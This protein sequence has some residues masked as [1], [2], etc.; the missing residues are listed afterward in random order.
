MNSIY[1]IYSK[2][3]KNIDASVAV[4]VFFICKTPQIPIYCRFT[5]ESI[6]GRRSWFLVLNNYYILFV[7]LKPYQ[8]LFFILLVCMTWSAHL[9]C[10]ACSVHLFIFGSFP[11]PVLT[12]TA[13]EIHLR[14]VLAHHGTRRSSSVC[15]CIKQ[16]L[17]SMGMDPTTLMLLTLGFTSR[18]IQTSYKQSV[19]FQAHL[20][21]LDKALSSYNGC[22]H[23]SRLCWLNRLDKMSWRL[24]TQCSW[25]GRKR[26]LTPFL[27][28]G[29]K[30]RCITRPKIHSR[31]PGWNVSRPFDLAGN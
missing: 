6:L 15:I 9:H 13:V 7:G 26:S 29:I 19:L 10:Q 25:H 27:S 8:Q 4:V 16:S 11:H 12:H 1:S 31:S 20:L 23:L 17:C 24:K 2:F 5:P 30:V 18:A 3:F 22:P 21:G 28:P 14:S